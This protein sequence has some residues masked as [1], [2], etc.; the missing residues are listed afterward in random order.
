MGGDEGLDVA[1]S[2]THYATSRDAM[3]VFMNRPLRFKP[4]SK[5]EYSSLAFTVAEAQLPEIRDGENPF[6]NSPPTFSRSMESPAFPSTILWPSFRV[7]CVV[8]LS[9]PRAKSNSTTDARLTGTILQKRPGAIT[10][11]RAYD[12]SNRY[13]AGGFDSSGESLLRFVLAVGAGKILSPQMVREMWTAQA[14]SDGSKGVFR[15]GWG[16]S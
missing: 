14:T 2:V 5:I 9:I 4:G 3:K 11:A 1:F 8:I 12:I 15:I 16:V 10:N 6:S 7:A 13:P